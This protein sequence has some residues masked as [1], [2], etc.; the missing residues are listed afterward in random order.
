MKSLRERRGSDT[1]P[2]IK[3]EPKS[4][5]II[6]TPPVPRGS[7]PKISGRTFFPS[8]ENGKEN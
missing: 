1:L 2:P 8:I 6:P 4:G 7:F 5:P 3:I